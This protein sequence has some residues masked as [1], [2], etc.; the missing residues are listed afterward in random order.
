MC[1]PTHGPA[2]LPSFTFIGNVI[3]FSV[4]SISRNFFR[5][6]DYIFN[7]G[8]NCLPISLKVD[9]CHGS[10]IHFLEGNTWLK[11]FV[12]VT[13]LHTNVF[14]EPFIQRNI[15]LRHLLNSSLKKAWVSPFDF[16]FFATDIISHSNI[17]SLFYFQF[18]I[19]TY[20]ETF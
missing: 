14:T 12:L 17:M 16:V 3:I 11:L 20:I 2:H 6:I 19:G 13:I 1:W 8:P 10:M 9:L 4:K 18:R 5:E 7:L 15:P